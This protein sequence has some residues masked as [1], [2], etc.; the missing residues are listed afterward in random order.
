M[1]NI[2]G[3]VAGEESEGLTV[4]REEK[5]SAETPVRSLVKVR[6]Q[7]DQRVLAYYNDRFD[8]HEGDLVHV[9]GKLSDRLGTVISVSTRF[10]IRLSDYEKITE[11]ITLSMSGRFR[12]VSEWM[13]SDDPDA[14]AAD[15]VRAWV[16]PPRP[17]TRKLVQLDPK[18]DG[19]S[20]GWAYV[21]EEDEVVLGEGFEAELDALEKCEDLRAAVWDRAVNYLQEGRVKYISL[22]RG[23]GTAFVEGTTW[24]EV[25]FRYDSGHVTDIY[26]DCPYPGMCKHETAALLA[27]QLLEKE[28][29]FD[30]E[31][32]FAAL[33]RDWFWELVE[34]TH[35]EID[36]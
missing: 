17:K 28:K 20:E 13:V 15:A 1:K 12:S 35:R 26:C 31:R 5:P 23:E 2:L 29:D 24:Y 34:L 16:K 30:P 7:E 10:K 8:L 6:F 19:V 9:S 32:D 22:R 27:L 11:K 18:L 21:E 25:N 33:D 36:L 3:F 4:P 14:L